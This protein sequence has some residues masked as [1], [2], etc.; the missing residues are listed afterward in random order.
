[1]LDNSID[2]N[3]SDNMS[4]DNSGL[5]NLTNVS[6][7]GDATGKQKSRL[8]HHNIRLNKKQSTTQFVQ[9][10]FSRQ[11]KKKKDRLRKDHPSFPIITK[12][13]DKFKAGKDIKEMMPVKSAAR[14]IYNI[15]MGKAA[16]FAQEKQN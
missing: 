1:M 16:E 13:L 6:E 14:Y 9:W 5:L 10:N 11:E 15:Y 4:A 7:M 3:D 8:G 12:L 2:L